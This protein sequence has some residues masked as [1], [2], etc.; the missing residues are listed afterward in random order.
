MADMEAAGIENAEGVNFSVPRKSEM[1]S[2]LKQRMANGKFYYPLTKLGT[3]LP[4]GHLQRT[5]RRTL[6]STAKMEP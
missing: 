6:S 5:K 3:T 4:R 1:A 2:V